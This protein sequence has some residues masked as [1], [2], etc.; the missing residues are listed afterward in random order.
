MQ[1]PPSSTGTA[2][3]IT[4]GAVTAIRGTSWPG[5]ALQLLLSHLLAGGAALGTFLLLAHS[6][7]SQALTLLMAIAGGGLVGVLLTMWLQYNLYVV[8]LLLARFAQGLPV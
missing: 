2:S 3:P 8:E 5:V 4:K 1:A 7:W 6:G